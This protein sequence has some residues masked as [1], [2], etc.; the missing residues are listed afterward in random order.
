MHPDDY[1]R[2]G[3]LQLIASMQPIH[4]TAD[5]LMAQRHWGTRA[6]GA[7]AWRTQ[8]N[9]GATL[10]FGSDAPVESI[11]PLDGIHAAVTRRRTD[12][13]ARTRWLVSTTAPERG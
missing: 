11:N 3:A 1:R 8:L 13:H 5:M 10:A 2:L 9:A 6:S 7:Y 4:A 12:G